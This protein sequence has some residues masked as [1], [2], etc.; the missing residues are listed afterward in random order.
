MDPKHLLD[1]LVTYVCFLPILTFH[2][3]AHAWV[4][5]KCGDDT[6]RLQGRVS[7]NP[8]VHMDLVGTVILPLV[9]VFLAASDSR[10]AGFIIGWGKPVPVDLGNLRHRR[11]DDT[12]VALAGP[13]MNVLLALALLAVLRAANL[14][15][16]EAMDEVLLRVAMLSLFLCFFNLLPI[17]PL[18][19]SH[20][21]KNLIGMRD[22]TYFRYSQFGFFLVILAI[23]IPLVN[24]FM[25]AA[26]FGT[27][28][29]MAAI[30]GFPRA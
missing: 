24:Q 8:A 21:L 9:A 30:L 2:E 16:V 11:R 28:Q 14:F 12:L 20:A 18:D 17:P 25:V 26:T 1:G 23:Q 13:M 6:A 4:A 3:F 15:Q 27:L 29:V 7:L 22:E 5:W 19:G 10:L